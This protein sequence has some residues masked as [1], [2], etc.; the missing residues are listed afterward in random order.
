[1]VTIKEKELRGLGETEGCG[2][3]LLGLFL[4]ISAFPTV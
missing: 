4:L 3:L 1:M 2:L